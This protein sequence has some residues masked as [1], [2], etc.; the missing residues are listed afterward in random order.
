MIQMK[1]GTWIDPACVTC[2]D[3]RMELMGEGYPNDGKR[4]YVSVHIGKRELPCIDGFSTN[5]E[6]VEYRDQLVA[7]IHAAITT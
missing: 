4:H 3:A 7:E 1:N 2:V 5:D 6:A